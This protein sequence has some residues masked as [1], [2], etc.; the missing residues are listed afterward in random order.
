M[1]LVHSL[2]P[3]TMRCNG[4]I[5]IASKPRKTI[6][7]ITYAPGKLYGPVKAERNVFIF[8]GR[9]VKVLKS[10]V[11]VR[12]FFKFGVGISVF[13]CGIQA[14]SN[15]NINSRI[16]RIAFRIT[17]SNC[18]LIIALDVFMNKTI[19]CLIGE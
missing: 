10:H 7:Q 12:C 19:L 1:G 3:T 4:E 17:N 13:L 8:I 9:L 14:Y 5:Q 16:R 11:S 2:L 15:S 6:F 18:I